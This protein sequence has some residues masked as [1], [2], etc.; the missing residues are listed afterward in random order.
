MPGHWWTACTDFVMSPHTPPPCEK[1]SLHLW[2]THW[3]TI[4]RY[5]SENRGKCNRNRCQ[6]PTISSAF[7]FFS[8]HW[9]LNLVTSRIQVSFLRKPL[10]SEFYK[11]FIR[12]LCSPTDRTG[13]CVGI[14]N[15]AVRISG[16][17]TK[18]LKQAGAELGHTCVFP[19]MLL[20]GV[21]FIHELTYSSL[22]PLRTPE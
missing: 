2:K 19:V 11:D 10:Q 16:P 21:S 6:S 13:W 5:K 7:K 12:I 15:F 20:V 1:F 17:D 22:L 18:N 4:T 14:R 3:I 8:T 9:L